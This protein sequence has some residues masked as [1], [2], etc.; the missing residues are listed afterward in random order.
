VPS[1]VIQTSN[2]SFS[3]IGELSLDL[4]YGM[5]LV[6]KSQKVTLY[7]VGDMIEGEDDEYVPHVKLTGV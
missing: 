1:G 6:T 3:Y 4:E 7:Q 5:S 2:Q